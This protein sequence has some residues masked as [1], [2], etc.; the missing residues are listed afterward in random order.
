MSNRKFNEMVTK[1]RVV[2]A[3]KESYWYADK[4]GE[5]FDVIR[6]S[7][8]S[9]YTVDYQSN[10]DDEPFVSYR[11]DFEDC[12]PVE[13]R[14][15]GERY[16]LESRKAE[17][18]EKVVVVANTTYHELSI[19]DVAEITEQ[20]NITRVC[21]S[22]KNTWMTPDCYRVLVPVE[23][24]KT[25]ALSAN[26][27]VTLCDDTT[28]IIDMLTAL[29]TEVAELKRKVETLGDAGQSIEIT[30]KGGNITWRA[31]SR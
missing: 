4:I 14:Y 10:E 15:N 3:E 27:N 22:K 18:G 21:T 23:E 7:N 5:V 16:R 12:E 19:G 20:G 11:V 6:L 30:V 8:N 24:A 1:V 9:G 31:E 17:V 25:S 2:S 26:V 13:I 28:K 29:S